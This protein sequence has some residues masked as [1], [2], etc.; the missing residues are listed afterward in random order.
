MRAGAALVTGAAR[1]IGRALA[2]A[3]AEDG[4]HVY[5]HCRRS[6]DEAEAAVAAI[7]ARG[8]SAD[9]VRADLA[10]VPEVE[11]LLGACALPGRPLT[12]LV[13]NASLFEYDDAAT[14]TASSWE[15]HMA[16]NLR[17]PALLARDFARALPRDA[18]GA[19]V[20][21]LDAK[22]DAPNPDFLSYTA[23]KQALAGLTRTLALALAPRVRVNGL[24]PGVTWANEAQSRE[25]FAR[26]QGLT[27]LGRGASPEDL[28]TALRFI[29]ACD[30]LTG[31]ILTLDGGQSLRPL[32]RD[33]LFLTETAEGA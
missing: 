27:P 26:A 5:V 4:W 23:S 9:V 2:S 15:R 13:N 31:E 25:G 12:C 28:V 18:Q 6:T 14:L 22:V 24:A 16:V 10:S 20:N 11:A 17:A 30:S 19:I 3:L 8:G 1:R 32:V 33:P 29:L 7:R 21:L